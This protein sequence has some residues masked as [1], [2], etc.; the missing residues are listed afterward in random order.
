MEENAKNESRY[1]TFNS[2]SPDRRIDYFFFNPEFIQ[3]VEAEVMHDAGQISDHL[4]V[5]MIFTFK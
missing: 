4:P 1:F 5:Q 2:V 3:F